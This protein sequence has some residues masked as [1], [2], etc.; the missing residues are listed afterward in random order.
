[1][2]KR[3]FDPFKFEPRKVRNRYSRLAESTISSYLGSCKLMCL[4]CVY[5]DYE[6]AK[7]CA[8]T[9]CAMWSANQRIFGGETT[10]TVPHGT[11]EESE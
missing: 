1:M 8:A 7:T 2:T 4:K 11:S 6:A 10:T 9:H 5:W 3:A